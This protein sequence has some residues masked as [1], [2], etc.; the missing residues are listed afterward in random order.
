[1]IDVD[2]QI[3]AP[4]EEGTANAVWRYENRNSFV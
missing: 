4:I 2:L 1:M 3:R